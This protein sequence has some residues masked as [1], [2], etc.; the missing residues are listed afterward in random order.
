[1]ILSLSGPVSPYSPNVFTAELSAER[2][3]VELHRLACVAV[4]T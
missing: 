2:G 3:L 1:M 4:R